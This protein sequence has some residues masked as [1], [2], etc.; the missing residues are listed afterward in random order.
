MKAGP[1]AGSAFLLSFAVRAVL[2]T[3]ALNAGFANRNSV[4]KSRMRRR[5]RT[6]A[7]DVRAGHRLCR[8]QS[9]RRPALRRCPSETTNAND[10]SYSTAFALPR[11]SQR[12]MVELCEEHQEK[13]VCRQLLWLGWHEQMPRMETFKAKQ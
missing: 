4:G 3:Y 10:P 2:P 7:V 5:S 9:E 12:D 1:L 13:A 11:A 6:D 8:E